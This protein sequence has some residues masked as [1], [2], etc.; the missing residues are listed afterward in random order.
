M[1]ITPVLLIITLLVALLKK[2]PVYDSFIEGIKEAFNLV[3]SLLP[4]LAAILIS[5]ELM[6]A[7]GLSQMLGRAVSP[8]FKVMGIPPQLCELLILRPLSGSGSLSL[9]EKIYADYGVD[10][11]IGRCASVIMGSSDTIF[12]IVAVYFSTSKDKKSGLAIPISVFAS[13][14]GAIASCALC[15]II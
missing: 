1:L 2:I 5:I 10:S 14:M 11:Y 9:L 4:Y 7:S 8:V 13:L 15:R 3:I 12:Y 6:R